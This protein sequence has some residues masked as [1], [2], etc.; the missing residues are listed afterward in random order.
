[1]HNKTSVF[2]L[3]AASSTTTQAMAPFHRQCHPHNRKRHPQTGSG[4]F[5]QAVA[6]SNWQRNPSSD[7]RTL[8]KD[9]G[10][11]QLKETTRKGDAVYREKHQQKKIGQRL[12]SS[13]KN[14]T[15][16]HSQQTWTE[17]AYTRR[18]HAMSTREQ[19]NK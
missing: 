13:S 7:G 15:V 16:T 1:M 6:P 11:S 3:T 8:T 9:S 5:K 19:V 14:S 10:T 4:T 12:H 18:L 17:A 2:T